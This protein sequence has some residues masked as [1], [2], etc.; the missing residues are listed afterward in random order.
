MLLTLFTVYTQRGEHDI[1]SELIFK[2]NPEFVFHD[3]RGF[4]AGTVDELELVKKFI[5]ERD[6]KTNLPD[7][8]HAIWYCHYTFIAMDTSIYLP[9]GTALLSTT[10]DRF[11]P[12]TKYFL[13][14][15][16][17]EKVRV[18]KTSQIECLELSLH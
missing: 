17:V 2:S 1:D 5:I 14:S 15:A 7:Q 6:D 3:S 9:L 18:S 12:P 8:L 13:M 11:W 10:T 16:I 4:E